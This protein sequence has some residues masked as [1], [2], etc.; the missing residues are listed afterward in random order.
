MLAATLAQQVC[1]V[2]GAV[3]AL[4]EVE[5]RCRAQRDAVRALGLGVPYSV[6]IR[7]PEAE[8]FTRTELRWLEGG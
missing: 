5:R 1:F 8:A 2:P 7:D 4:D 3:L 6:T